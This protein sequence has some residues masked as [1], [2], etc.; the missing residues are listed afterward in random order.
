MADRYV[1]FYGR[2]GKVVGVHGGG[3]R[4]AVEVSGKTMFVKAADTKECNAG[5]GFTE[6]VFKTKEAAMAAAA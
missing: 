6:R 2:H 1:T 5:G 3:K 4:L